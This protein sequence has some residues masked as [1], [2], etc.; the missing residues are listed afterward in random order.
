ME[1]PVSNELR[2]DAELH[3]KKL[4]LHWLLQI[5]KAINY[6]LP[7]Q[8]LFGI[9]ETVMRDQLKV[10]KLV[11]YVHEQEWQRM[12]SFGVEEDFLA[13]DASARL[14][15]LNMLQQTNVHM[16]DWVNGFD[17]II[18][19]F[20]DDKPLAYAFIADLRHEEISSLKEVL[21]FIHTIT[22]IIVVAIE[23]KRLT[24]NTIRQAQ[25]QLELELAA[26][27]Q[28][29][30][31]P[32]HLPDDR[33]IDLAATY[34]PHQEVGGDYYDYIQIAPDEWLICL[35]DVSGKGISAALL[36]SNFQANLNAK[37]RHFGSLK[38]LV[39]E[40]N[41]SVNKSA[42]GEKF[43]TAFF[44]VLNTKTHLL[45]YINAGQ[46]PPFIF[47]NGEFVLL[48]KGTTGLG[49]FEE[50]PFVNEGMTYVHPGALLFC[51]TDG[52]VEQEN[53]AGDIFG[54]EILM[55]LIRDNG[56]VY[57]M[58]DLHFRVLDAFNAF[59]KGAEALDD[60]TLLSIRLLGA[61]QG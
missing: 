53:S 38:E 47:S 42:K 26:L 30:L 27:M 32:A 22:N 29:M 23:N 36:M 24:K 10:C 61:D 5:T 19:V 57:R 6:N 58:Q 45:Q 3:V 39:V 14:A 11:L 7:S 12:L 16:P 21:P 55:E 13:E 9:Y 1:K 35:A 46:N 41:D 51:Y 40:L 33:R 54:L 34:L 31:F 18:P 8:Q 20:H 44:G 43:I 17:S 48:D 50:L 49:M 2:S 4:Q 52:I 56:D 28:S 59:R 37:S 60:V 15:E 25:L